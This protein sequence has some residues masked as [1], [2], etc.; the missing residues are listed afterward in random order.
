MAIIEILRDD[1]INQIAAGEVIERPASVVKE[2][3]DNALDAAST[4]I[5]VDILLGGKRLIRVCDNGCGMDREDAIRCIQ[6]HATSKIKEAED[7]FNITTMGF[8][9]E[10][11]SSIAAV[12]KLTISTALNSPSVPSEGTFIEVHGGVVKDV[13]DKVTSGTTIEV[14]D[15]FY[16]TPV[17]KRF[18]KGTSTELYHITETV[19]Q[20]AL[21]N[22]QRRLSLYIDEK[23]A[24]SL[25]AASGIDERIAMLYGSDFLRALL[26]FEV[27]GDGLSIRGFVSR[28]ESARKSRSHQYIFVNNRCIRDNVIRH[29]VYQGFKDILREGAHPVFFLYIESDP[30]TVDCNVHPTKQEIRFLHK[31]YIY[32][33]VITGV[34]GAI[35][36]GNDHRANPAQSQAQS[37]STPLSSSPSIPSSKPTPATVEAGPFKYKPKEQSPECVVRESAPLPYTP[38]RD[39]LYL[40]D[41]FVA[42]ADRDRLVIADHHAAHERVMYERLRDGVGLVTNRLLFPIQLKLPLKEFSL[43]RLNMDKVRQMGIEIEEFGADTF[44]IR[45]V[46]AE[47]K[48]VDISA[49]LSDIAS[50][51]IDTSAVSPTDDIKDV[52]AKRIACHSAVRGRVVLSSEELN[53]LFRQLVSTNDPHH[54]PHGRPTQVYLSHDDLRKMFKRK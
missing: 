19:T 29:A 22:P 46:P 27:S 49:V 26:P 41:V 32:Q 10:A 47:L 44:I 35:R 2:L 34:K 18:L 16:N 1:L 25:P 37:A 53:A 48:G 4:D 20:V 15:L 50:S 36:Q 23:E 51:M 24:L 14:R 17:R 42:Y 8:R 39:Y 21:I 6:R 45:G 7:L 5:R 11:L 52:M 38:S 30:A 43:L 3:V 31:D 33:Q 13:R 28:A 12:S 54:C 40:G 9:G